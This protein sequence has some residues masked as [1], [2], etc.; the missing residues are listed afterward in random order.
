ML[1]QTLQERG[2]VAQCTNEEGLSHLLSQPATLGY[3][4]Y[5]PTATSLHVGH[6]LPI[7]CLI[8]LQRAGHVPVV[9]VGGGTGLIGDPSGRTEMRNFLTLDKLQ[10]NVDAIKNQ[11]S[12]FLDFDR[13]KMVNNADW[14]LKLNYLEFLRDVG[15]HF[16]VNRMLAAESVKNRLE[17][18]MNFI[19]F[20]YSLLQAYDFMHLAKHYNCRLQLGG[21][22]Q[23]GNIVAGVDL[24]R[25]MLDVEVYGLTMPLLTTAGGA[26][27]G[28]TA[29]GAV[30]LDAQRTPV[31]DFYQFWVN[32]ADEDVIRFL[33]FFTFL[34]MSKIDDLAR[35]EGAQLREAKQILA[36]EV[37]ALVH[38]AASADEARAAAQA[39]FGGKGGD[40]NS[41]P[42]TIVDSQRLE[43]GI[44]AFML[45]YESGLAKSSSEARRLISQGGAYIGEEKINTFD[46]LIDLSQLQADGAIWLRAGKKKHHRIV[47]G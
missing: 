28:K 23:W 1:Y 4:G 46:Q 6:L 21:N 44:P 37:C 39:A 18:G 25:R 12:R 14:L 45:L 13:A 22:D 33:K 3:I 24:A 43:Q 42:T 17:R 36:W 38:G 31:Y 29:S 9:L 41:M 10:E 30:W 27:M 20:N 11:L 19:E 35:L 32:T 16:S 47:A 26:K 15:R 40:P 34:E 8:H 2:F 5:D 7:I